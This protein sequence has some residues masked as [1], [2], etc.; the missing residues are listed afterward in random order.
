MLEG[1]MVSLTGRVTLH[2][3]MVEAD[4]VLKIKQFDLKY[5]GKRKKMEEERVEKAK[6]KAKRDEEK[7]KI[8]KEKEKDRAKA[9]RK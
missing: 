2:T 4:S 3:T 7:A 8:Q 6:L 1:D 5:P 9:K